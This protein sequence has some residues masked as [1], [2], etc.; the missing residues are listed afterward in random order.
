MFSKRSSKPR[1]LCLSLEAL[2]SRDLL[3]VVSVNASQIVQPVSPHDLGVNVAWWDSNLN[4][5]QTAQMVKAAGL[6]MFRF[7]GGSSSDSW[8]FSAPPTYNGEGT[9]PS[10]AEFIASVQ[11]AGMITLDYGSASPQEAAAWL[12]YLNG[13]TTNATAIGMGPQ[14]NDA[15]KT[16]VQKDWKTAGYWA[17]LRAAQPL[18]QNDGLNFLRIGR[19]A[20]FG[21]HYYEV[22]NEIY[23]SW[24]T[25]HHGQ[26]G[27]P[28]LPHDPATYIAFAKQFASYAALIDNTISIGLD[29]GSI[30]YF[31]NWTQKILQQSVTQHF[32]PGF[33]SDHSYMQN[34][35]NES[36]SY[37]L[38]NT[39]SDPN[40]QDPNN[41]LDWP[42]RAKGYRN[43]LN[44]ILGG[45]ASQVELLATEFNSVSYNPGKQTTSLVNG[46]FVAD[47]IGSI[48]QTEYKSALIWDLRNGWDTGHNNS[49]SLYGWRQGGDYGLL[50]GGGPAPSTGTYIPYPNYFAEQLLSKMVLAGTSVVQTS[51]DTPTLSA[52]AV[53]QSNGHLDLLVINKDPSQNVTGRFQITGFQPSAQAR[54]WQYGK[55]Q[56]TAQSHTTDGH[57]ALANFA[58]TLV[59]SGSSFRY[60][61]PSYSMTVIDLTP[62]ARALVFRPGGL[63]LGATGNVSRPGPSAGTL[64]PPIAY[65]VP[66][67]GATPFA[68]TTGGPVGSITFFLGATGSNPIGPSTFAMTIPNA[69][70]GLR[71]SEVASSDTSGVSGPRTPVW[72]V[73]GIANHQP[74]EVS[75]WAT[76]ADIV[77]QLTS[78]ADVP[79]GSAARKT[80]FFPF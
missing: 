52:Y 17:S 5:A 25:D 46:L 7:P 9:A 31:N 50:G 66:N 19:S 56:D 64:L 53:R 70:E 42:L 41:P 48:L 29:V 28:G 18:A 69:V 61:F 11:G 27:S 15:T 77:E 74:A 16:W 34:P 30:G 79:M 14:W 43:L 47:S 78:D 21:F 23:G 54:F 72:D 58:V 51:S 55:S 22:G 62:H 1:R 3:A 10:M 20:A 12:A 76:I 24:E 36:D 60:T 38:L 45:A 4:T 57:S 37:L 63:I 33:L 35:G 67:A 75:P 65:G 68:S 2:E 59:L 6:S 40:N 71:R 13:S 39:V 80:E 44:Q 26:G 8:H 49:S 73:P 32:T